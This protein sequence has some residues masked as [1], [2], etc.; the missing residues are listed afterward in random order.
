MTG[1]DSWKL[2][3]APEAD[4]GDDPPRDWLTPRRGSPAALWLMAARLRRAGGLL[5]AWH[6]LG[7]RAAREG[8]PSGRLARRRRE[9]GALADGL[10]GEAGRLG[11]SEPRW[12]T[13]VLLV[14]RAHEGRARA[15]A[16]RAERAYLARLE[17]RGEEVAA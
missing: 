8:D 9:V 6:A 11:L 7:L 10:C 4:W 12:A 15:L 14:R 17:R 1:Y 16:L 5:A 2:A 3:S 13:D